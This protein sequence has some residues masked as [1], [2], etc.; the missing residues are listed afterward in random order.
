MTT[1]NSMN[2]PGRKGLSRLIAA[3][4]YSMRGLRA[5]WQHEEGFRQESLLMLPL[6]PLA[7]WLAAD[8]SQFLLMFTA[9]ALVLLAELLNSALEAV[10]DR[11]G[12]EHHPLSGQAKDIGSAAVFVCLML[13]LVIWGSILWQRFG[14]AAA[15]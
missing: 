14:A 5:A 6:M 13:F 8:L 10:V 12:P 15:T 7:A 2:K 9:C 4:N 3:T 1:N 11:I